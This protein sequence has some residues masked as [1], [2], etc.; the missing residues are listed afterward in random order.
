V[1]AKPKE[2]TAVEESLTCG[3]FEGS[4]QQSAKGSSLFYAS[5]THIVTVGDRV[6]KKSHAIQAKLLLVGRAGRP[7]KRGG[8]PRA[9]WVVPA[10]LPVSRARMSTR[11]GG[12]RALPLNMWSG[13][14]W[15]RDVMARKDWQG[16]RAIDDFGGCAVIRAWH[17]PHAR[18]TLP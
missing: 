15:Y 13:E 18:S 10:R 11:G 4:A 6:P 14:E 9:R 7:G 3:L 2:A 8:L 17:L 1:T 5:P 16:V 12:S